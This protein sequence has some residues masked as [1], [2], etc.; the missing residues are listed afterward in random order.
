[1]ASGL[2]LCFAL[3]FVLPAQA[4][5]MPFEFDNKAEERRFK[6]LMEELRCLVCQNQSL[7]DSNAELA[8]DLRAEVYAQMN[9][10]LDN[11]E[12]TAFLVTRYGDFVLYRPPLKRH[13]WILWFGP[14]VLLFA[15]GII[16]I[17]LIINHTRQPAET[18]TGEQRRKVASL[19]QHKD[20]G[21]S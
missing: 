15:G 3:L 7:A 19:L 16:V 12:I 6:D 9:A 13:T 2:A 17:R 21:V 1:M 14:F 18:L 10:G 20:D 8:Q 11:E 5:D 4:A